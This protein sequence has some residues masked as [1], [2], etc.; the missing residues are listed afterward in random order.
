MTSTPHPFSSTTTTAT[1]PYSS[2]P[3]WP[4]FHIFS[5]P[6]CPLLNISSPFLKILDFAIA[7]IPYSMHEPFRERV[8]RAGPV[9]RLHARARELGGARD[10]RHRPVRC[11]PSSR[12]DR[13]PRHPGVHPRV[14]GIA[15][16][17]T[18]PRSEEHT[19]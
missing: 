2:P 10:R 18:A 5:P 11:P 3:Q 4:T 1:S 9:G 15:A 8:A 16:S 14:R 6:Q 17:R 12:G 13:L 7:A 19:S